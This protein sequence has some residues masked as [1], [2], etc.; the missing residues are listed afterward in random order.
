[1][2]VNPLEYARN[3]LALSLLW[4]AVQGFANIAFLCALYSM[5]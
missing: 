4:N 2:T 1:M 5:K 3:K